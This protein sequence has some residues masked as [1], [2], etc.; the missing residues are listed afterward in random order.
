MILES[1]GVRDASI[2]RAEGEKQKVIKES[3]ATRQQQMNEAEGEA[4]AIEAV[5]SATAQG[6]REVG[7][8][9]ASPGGQEAMQLRIAEQY[10]TQ[11]GQLAKEA[12]TLV[13]PANLSDIASML[14]LATNIVKRNGD[15]SESNSNGRAPIPRR[16]DP[17]SLV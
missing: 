16:D 12:N 10:V 1:E 5:A 2:N 8:A 11:F 4:A 3:E 6:L 9:V 13:I 15:G 17:S 14:S 7:G